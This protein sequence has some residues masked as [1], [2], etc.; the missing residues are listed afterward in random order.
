MKIIKL[1]LLL[2]LLVIV[3]ISCKN[4]KKETVKGS[5]KEIAKIDEGTK[6]LDNSTLHLSDTDSLYLKKR[7][8]VVIKTYEGKLVIGHEVNSIEIQDYKLGVW[9]S[10]PKNLVGE[11]YDK[12]TKNKKAYTPVFVKVKGKMLPKALDGFAEEYGNVLEVTELIE[13]KEIK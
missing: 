3:N 2:F 7:A 9:F 6:I 10:D 8:E 13:V 5:V 4:K 1:G 12:L 11:K